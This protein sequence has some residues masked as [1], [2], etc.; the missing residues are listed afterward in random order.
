ME[1]NKSPRGR[2]NSDASDNS[3]EG[4]RPSMSI[5]IFGKDWSEKS[6]VGN[7]ILGS[8]A[9]ESHPPLDLCEAAT[10][11]VND[12]LLTVVITPNLI[13]NQVTQELLTQWVQKCV[14]LCGPGPRANVMVVQPQNFAKIDFY[15]VKRIFTSVLDQALESTLVVKLL[16]EDEKEAVNDNESDAMHCLIQYC[17]GECYRFNRKDEEEHTRVEILKKIMTE[18]IFQDALKDQKKNPEIAASS[19]DVKDQMKSVMTSLSQYLPI[20]SKGSSKMISQKAESLLPMN[21]MLFGRKGVQK[22]AIGNIILSKSHSKLNLSSNFLKRQANVCGYSITL[23]EVPS[24]ANTSLSLEVVLQKCYHSISQCAPGIDAFLLTLPNGPLTDED[25]IEIQWIETIFGRCVNDYI[26]ILYTN[27]SCPKGN[28]VQHDLQEEKHLEQHFRKGCFMLHRVSGQEKISQMIKK[29]K[30]KSGKCFTTDMFVNAQIKERVRVQTELDMEKKKSLKNPQV[31]QSQDSTTDVRIVLIGKTGVGKSATG[32]TILGKNTFETDICGESVTKYCQKDIGDVNGKSV[33]VVDTPGLFDTTVSNEEVRKEI[34]KCFSYLAPGPH[35]FLLVLG[36]GTRMTAEEKETLKLIEDAFGT[37]AGK[38]IIVLF[39]KADLLDGLSFED[40]IKKSGADVQKLI[41]DC[42]R[43]YHA[44]NNKEKGN[45]KQ[46]TELMDKIDRMVERNGGGCYTNE[47]FQMAESAIKEKF[48]N[49]MREREEEIER[50]KE[51]L[52]VKF[53]EDKKAM[54]EEQIRAIQMEREQRERQLREKEEYIN[55][56]LQRRD[57]KE[58]KERE[59]REA[60]DKMRRDEEEAKRLTWTKTLEDVERKHTDQ[61]EDWER[62]HIKRLKEEKERAEREHN[63]WIEK[64]RKE[65][66]EF[67]RRQE[68]ER[69]TKDEEEERRKEIQEHEKNKLQAKVKEA[70]QMTEEIRKERLEQLRMWE[71]QRMREKKKELDERDEWERLQK[72]M[73][74]NFENEKERERRIRDA[75][76]Q[77]RRGK[78]RKERERIEEEHAEKIKQMKNDWEKQEKE[79]SKAKEEEKERREKED[80]KSREKIRRLQAEFEKEKEDEKKRRRKED[81]D[82]EKEH[83]KKLKETEEENQKKI[84]ELIKKHEEEVRKKAEEFNDFLQKHIKD[85][86]GKHSLETDELKE[87]IEEWKNKYNKTCVLL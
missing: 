18:S 34:L 37:S 3:N 82:R 67:E 66:S 83:K 12:T 48:E 68:A 65:R 39:T 1:P 69:R 9:F 59:E 84:E 63:E 21:L 58:K 56:E 32:N 60:E 78:E 87:K 51:Q 75:E 26:M 54:M 62:E 23:V 80:E 77:E 86:E 61:K 71:D 4:S 81:E 8:Y 72:K 20:K 64:Q 6:C 45:R 43:R 70:E 41:S 22:T 27:M 7:V 28:L 24:L 11:L 42:E 29:I 47:M 35:V 46:V 36:V 5:I 19:K 25:K 55:S 33:A 31:I 40:Y 85:L 16:T 57:E 49:M 52:L 14:A 17:G 44:F 15:N 50:E 30:G 2:T 13:S 38:F 73:K 10:E 76:E 53:E 74:E 79:W